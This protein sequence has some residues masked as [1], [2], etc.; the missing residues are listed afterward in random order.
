MRCVWARWK[1]PQRT[2]T[3]F[4][5]CSAPKSE[6]EADPAGN[7]ACA[8]ERRERAHESRCTERESVKAPTEQDD[9]GDER[10]HARSAATRSGRNDCGEQRERMPE[11]VLDR[12]VPGLQR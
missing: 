5:F 7:E 3:N 1:R 12:R 6:A 8:A 9:P 11:L 4:L 2:T 10:R